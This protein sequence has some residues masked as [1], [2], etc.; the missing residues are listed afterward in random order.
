MTGA[1]DDFDVDSKYVAVAGLSSR[2]V[3]R[4]GVGG[5]DPK[6]AADARSHG[7]RIKVSQAELGTG[8]RH[9]IRGRW[10]YQQQPVGTQLLRDGS[11]AA[12]PQQTRKRVADHRVVAPSHHP[13]V[14]IKVLL[15]RHER[16]SV[17][18]GQAR[19]KHDMAFGSEA[20]GE[21]ERQCDGGR[22]LARPWRIRNDDKWMT[23]R[24]E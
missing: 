20:S 8:V 24:P 10:R 15:P 19:I 1:R 23:V 5:H 16:W 13:K 21:P 17:R 9:L 2:N 11:C 14:A 7:R 4:V 22:W 3:V 6:L 18:I 12:E